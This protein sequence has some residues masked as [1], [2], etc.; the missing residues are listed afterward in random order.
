MLNEAQIKETFQILGIPFSRIAEG[1]PIYITC[2]FVEKHT[3]PTGNKNTCLYFD[4]QPHV[5]CFHTHAGGELRELNYTLRVA[6]TGSAEYQGPPRVQIDSVENA[7]RIRQVEIGRPKI[8]EKFKRRVRTLEKIDLT[9]AEFLSRMTLFG[10]E[11]VIW[12]GVPTDSGAAWAAKHFKTLAKWQKTKIPRSWCYTT[13][14]VYVPR[15]FSRCDANVVTRKY[16]ILESDILSLDET[17]AVI[18]WVVHVFELPLRAVVFSGN[19]SLHSWY[20]YPG[21][22]WVE[23]NG[24]DL[25]AAGFCKSTFN[26]LSQPVRL[27]GA[28]NQKTQK[29]QEVLYLCPSM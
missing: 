10:P 5:H 15:T 17:R 28:V 7:E 26:K 9:P 23:E 25:I 3:P 22:A 21:D 13:G 6:V 24:A 8:I 19:R 29:L 27:G 2:P 18:E 11:D 14:C 1:S 16:L 12:C 4:L 20:D